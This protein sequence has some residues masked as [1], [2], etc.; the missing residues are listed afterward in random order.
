MARLWQRSSGQRPDV[1]QLSSVNPGKNADDDLLSSFDP[2]GPAPPPVDPPASSPSVT[3]A[4]VEVSPDQSSMVADLRARFVLAE[5]EIKRSTVEVATL[6]T[7]L[8]TIVSKVRDIEGRLGPRARSGRL[9]PATAGSS[10]RFASAAVLALLVVAN[11]IAWRPVLAPV[12]IDRVDPLVTSPTLVAPEPSAPSAIAPSAESLSAEAPPAAE[13]LAEVREPQVVRAAS[14][15]SQQFRGTLLVQTEPAGA[16]VFVNRTPVGQTP[17]RVPA[18]RAGSHL[19]WLERDGYK[20]WTS[21]VTV[22]ADQTT[23]VSARLQPQ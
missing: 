23:R 2:E 7:Q 14:R 19:V 22:P 11:A 3:A 15:E 17:L 10:R 9:L 21:V 1:P 5:L 12:T 6:R 8:E 18:L 20:R 13:P 4:P 16:A